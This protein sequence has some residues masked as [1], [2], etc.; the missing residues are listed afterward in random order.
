MDSVCIPKDRFFRYHEKMRDR[1]IGRVVPVPY[2]TG[3]NVIRFEI[4]RLLCDVE[5]FI[6]QKEVME[7]YGMGFCYEKAYDGTKIKDISEDVKEKTLRYY[8]EHHE[9][10]NRKCAGYSK[11]LFIDLH[12]YSDE[13]IP[14]DIVEPAQITPDVCIG[15][16]P[17]Y[18]PKKLL[19]TV[20]D[21]FEAAGFTTAVNYPYS[22]CFVPDIIVDGECETD[23]VAIMIE[24]NRRTYC[25]EKNNSVPEKTEKIRKIMQRIIE[26]CI[27]I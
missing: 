23:C 15:I 26:E 6:G 18:T 1:D 24:L 22:G 17:A 7:Q 21:C 12:S 14:V 19:E 3:S 20:K 5:R 4:S 11:V 10:V 13:I 16:D 9:E 8:R 2:K 27:G 25:D